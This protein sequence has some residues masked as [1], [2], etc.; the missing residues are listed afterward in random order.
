M[1]SAAAP[2]RVVIADDHDL[3]R[4]G[5]RAMLSVGA[6]I[7]V[8]GDAS[9]G[10]SAIATTIAMRPDVLLLDVEM[11]GVPVLSTIARVLAESPGTRIVI[12]TMHRDRVLAGHLLAAG[13]SAFISKSATSAELIDAVRRATAGNAERVDAPPAPSVLSH[14]EREVLKLI[15]DGLSNQA[16]GQR[17]SISTGTVKRHNTHIF[18]KLGASSR[19]DAVRRAWTLGELADPRP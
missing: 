13:A 15:G 3:F 4:D 19:T 11:P 10:E 9:D 18:A 2:I 7:A 8:V 1:N 16:I 6:R 5:M 17:L 12:V 14:R